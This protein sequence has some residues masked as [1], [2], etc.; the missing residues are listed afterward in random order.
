MPTYQYECANCG[1]SFEQ[2]QSMTDPKLRKCPQCSKLKLQ[3]LI[4][5]GSGLIFKGTGFYQTDYKKKDTG[6][7][8]D[9]DSSPQKAPTST[10]DTK[11][12]GCAKGGCSCA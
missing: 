2:L 6:P 12:H 1:H 5:T 9:K 11:G 8:K 10:A 3:R 4:G 7:S